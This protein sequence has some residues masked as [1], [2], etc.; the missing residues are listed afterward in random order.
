MSSRKL[1]IITCSNAVQD[2]DC[3]AIVCLADLHKR[4]GKYA[5][6][7]PEDTL[8]LTG[9]ISC[10][11]CPTVTYPEKIL[12]KVRGLTRYGIM[13]IHLSNCM[14]ELCPFV[15]KYAA[16]ITKAFPE[17]RLVMGTHQENITC[18]EFQSMVA[19]AFAAGKTMP[20]LVLGAAPQ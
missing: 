12:R 2:L 16:V 15:K 8:R 6:Y 10:S 20:D 19:S 1:G 5:E 3:C 4:K 11:G 17:V 9:I 7:P 14:V 13:D 18:A